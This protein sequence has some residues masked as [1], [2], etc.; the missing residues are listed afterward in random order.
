MQ[1]QEKLK[2]THV[3]NI[4]ADQRHAFPPNDEAIQKILVK[5][6][7]KWRAERSSQQIAEQTEEWKETVVLSSGG[8]QSDVYIAS[9]DKRD[10]LPETV[11]I[12]PSGKEQESVGP[13]RESPTEGLK[14]LEET[15]SFQMGKKGVLQKKDVKKTPDQNVLT[16]T[17]VLKPSKK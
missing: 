6:L 11:I 12:T 10:E 15:T 7:A 13:L 4:T 3:D 2:N 17:V 14:S 9:Q 5:V 16:E 8:G 1:N